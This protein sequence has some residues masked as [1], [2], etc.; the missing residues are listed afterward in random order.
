MARSSGYYNSEFDGVRL[1]Q[2]SKTDIEFLERKIERMKEEIDALTDRNA[3]LSLDL[4]SEKIKTKLLEALNEIYKLEYV[5]DEISTAER[6]EAARL[7][8]PNA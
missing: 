3:K 5:N 6:T 1:Q 2:Q 8:E 7:D 4:R